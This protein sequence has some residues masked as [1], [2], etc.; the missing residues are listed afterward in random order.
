MPRRFVSLKPKTGQTEK[1]SPRRPDGGAALTQARAALEAGQTQDALRRL[2]ALIAQDRENA[3]ALA[4]AGIACSQIGRHAEAM[5]YLARAVALAPD[6]AQMRDNLGTAFQRAG[7][8]R[9]AVE[10]HQAAV[11]LNPQSAIAHYNLAVALQAIG[12]LASA[13]EHYRASLAIFPSQPEAHTNLAAILERQ[14]DL[15]A[16][17]AHARQALALRPK[18][19]EAEINVGLRLAQ[20]KEWSEAQRHFVEAARSAPRHMSALNQLA[21][22]GAHLC[23]WETLERAA[24]TLATLTHEALAIGRPAPTLPFETLYYPWPYALQ[25]AVARAHAATLVPKDVPRLAPMPGA[26]PERL[27]VAYLSPDFSEHAVGFLVQDLFA[28]HDRARYVVSAYALQNRE[29]PVQ[30]TIVRS[31]DNYIRLAGLSD[32]EA[33]RRIAADGVH[34]LIDLAGHTAGART[35]ILA[36]RPAAAQAAMLGYPSTLGADYIRYFITAR[37]NIPEA[38]AAHFA[39]TLVLLPQ[40][41]WATRSMSMPGQIP[42]RAALGLPE[43]GPVACCFANAYRIDRAVFDAWMRI[44]SRAPEAVLWLKGGDSAVET[45][46]RKAAEMRGVDPRRL[47]FND[48]QPLSRFWPHA[49]ADLWL[50]TFVLTA[51]TASYLCA[52]A[53]VPVLTLAGETPQARTGA[54]FAVA[55]GTPELVAT[56]VAEYEEKAVRLLRRSD[57]LPSLRQRLIERREASPLFDQKRFVGR[58]EAAFEAIWEHAARRDPAKLIAIAAN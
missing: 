34:V 10:H 30:A 58:L 54:A 25:A 18:D 41:E 24:A 33:A 56:S 21:R 49:R 5:D 15:D 47:V 45:R 6:S 51:G 2:E 35:E 57:E 50:D 29:D 20:R 55:A 32:A 9:S 40:T 11:R 17:L 53:G 36:Y 44:L 39:E 1:P 7:D 42:T 13:V 52:W 23:D 37:E 48:G 3:D 43:G 31:A 38:A 22:A 8:M 27:H 12:E 16:A 26:R 28:H 46:L 19:T 4:L 14:G